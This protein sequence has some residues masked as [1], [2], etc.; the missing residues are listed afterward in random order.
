MGNRRKA[1]E[2][3]TQVLFHMEYN[4]GDPEKNF[5]L[6]CN[7]FNAPR[8]LRLFAKELIKGICENRDHIDNIIQKSSK[9]WKMGRMSKV[10]RSILRLSVY[11][12]FF[13]DDIPPKVSIDEAVEL[14][15]KFGTEESG[16]FING[17]LDNV[18]IRNIKDDADG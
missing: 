7:N 5:E 14:G 13:L 10:D 3:V 6:I 18:Y 11:E 4:P 15:K 8:S 16:S 12:M 1:R 9:N 2:L 17:I